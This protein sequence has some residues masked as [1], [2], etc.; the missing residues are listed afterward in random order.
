[1]PA[2]LLNPCWPLRCPPS[3][4]APPAGAT[5]TQ[6]ADQA[7]RIVAAVAKLLGPGAVV[8][9]FLASVSGGPGEE[10]LGEAAFSVTSADQGSGG[11]KGS[12]GLYRIQSAPGTSPFTTPS[13]FSGL[14]AGWLQFEGPSYISLQEDM[15]VQSSDAAQ[16]GAGGG[17]HIQQHKGKGGAGVSKKDTASTVNAPAAAAGKPVVVTLAAAGDDPLELYASA[18][19]AA[20]AATLVGELAA[21]GLVLEKQPAVVPYLVSW[22]TNVGGGQSQDVQ[23]ATPT[24]CGGPAAPLCCR[25]A[26]L[27]SWTPPQRRRRRPRPSLWRQRRLLL[28]LTAPPPARPHPAQRPQL[29]APAAAPAAPA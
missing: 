24:R 29:L 1:M 14:D 13:P 7:S 21:M 4:V 26:R 22:A 11:S 10:A 25:P 12:G 17:K 3:P 2:A 19:D 16:G 23:G 27:S 8:P 6:V 18:S 28:R 9:P 15:S 5:Q 20:A